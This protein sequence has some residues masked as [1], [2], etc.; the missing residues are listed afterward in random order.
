MVVNIVIMR[1]IIDGDSCPTFSLIECI[2]SKYGIET[3]DF[4]DYTHNITSDYIKVISVDKGYQSVDMKILSFIKNDDILITNDYGLAALGLT[5]HIMII[6]N[7]GFI[8]TNKN[9]DDLLNMSYLS[10]KERNSASKTHLKGPAP[11]IK[12]D[13]DN[14]ISTL[15]NVIKKHLIQ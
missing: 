14:F 3:Y 6:S 10:K 8:Y 9:I 7:K 12:D 1:I 2:A 15:E 4:F 11:R 13:D 5:R